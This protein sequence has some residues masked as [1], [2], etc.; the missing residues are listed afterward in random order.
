LTAER[1]NGCE[2]AANFPV[3]S[4]SISCEPYLTGL[5]AVEECQTYLR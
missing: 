1:I 3:R 2:Y 4:A 5:K